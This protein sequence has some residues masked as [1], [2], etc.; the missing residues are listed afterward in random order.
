MGEIP[1]CV[2]SNPTSSPCHPLYQV[3]L[4]GSA[5]L[6]HEAWARMQGVGTHTEQGLGKGRGPTCKLREHPFPRLCHTLL[7]RHQ[8]LPSSI[9]CPFY[10]LT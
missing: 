10:P 5:G 7:Q 9:Q 6:L 8:S 1:E 2:I 4:P 3:L